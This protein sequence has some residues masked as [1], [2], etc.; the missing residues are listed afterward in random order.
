MKAGVHGAP[1]FIAWKDAGIARLAA[2]DI[3]RRD[4]IFES[5]AR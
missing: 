4:P 3:L 1:L 2:M 5:K